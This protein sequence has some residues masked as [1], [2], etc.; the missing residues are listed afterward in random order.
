MGIIPLILLY[1]IKPF[2]KTKLWDKT[3]PTI[4]SDMDQYMATFANF[5][6]PHV[7]HHSQQKKPNK[8]NFDGV[9]SKI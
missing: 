8:W 4:F 6:D 1:L 7:N 3:L 2:L 5:Q 9:V